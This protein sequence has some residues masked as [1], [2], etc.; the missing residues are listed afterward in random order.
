MVEKINN[1]VC[2]INNVHYICS[3]NEKI[4]QKMKNKELQDSRMRQYFIDATK[5]ILKGEG[6]QGVSVRNI[7]AQAGYSFATLYN[8]FRDV[9]DLVFLC[10][11]DFQK[12]CEEWVEEKTNDLPQGRDRLKA[13]IKA[14]MGYFIEYPGIFEMFYIN[15]V[16]DFGNKQ[17]I[18]EVVDNSLARVS[19]DLWDYCI[20]NDLVGTRP[21][22]IRVELKYITLGLLVLYLNRRVPQSYQEFMDEVEKQLALLDG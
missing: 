20:N 9:N 21:N 4:L 1:T 8:Y 5:Q 6:I 3:V 7:A 17:P 14:W 15:R 12:E 19:D 11:I 10:I 2:Y 22:N 18:I 16:N 13:V